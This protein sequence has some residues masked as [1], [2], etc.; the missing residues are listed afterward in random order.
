MRESWSKVQVS[1]F[2]IVGILLIFLLVAVKLGFTSDDPNNRV[3]NAYMELVPM[4]VLDSTLC[5]PDFY[6]PVCCS[7]GVTYD[8]LCV[9]KAADAIPEYQGICRS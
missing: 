9:C 1:I 4:D 7:D 8:N 5:D 6:D 3:G 2:G